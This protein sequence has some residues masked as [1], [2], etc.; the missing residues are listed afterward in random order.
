[1]PYTNVIFKSCKYIKTNKADY[2][3]FAFFD[4]RYISLR[5]FES[6]V[7]DHTAYVRSA[8]LETPNINELD[9]IDTEIANTYAPETAAMHSTARTLNMHMIKSM[10]YCDLTHLYS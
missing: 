10:I 6:E 4:N 3:G 1:M 2:G 7:R 9:I 8:F 5:I